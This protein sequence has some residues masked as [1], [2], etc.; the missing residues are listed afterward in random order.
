LTKPAAGTLAAA[1][2]R[3][4]LLAWYDVHARD[5]PWRNAGRTPYRVF[6]SEAMLQQTRV[7][8]VVPYFDRFVEKLPDFAALADADEQEVLGLWQGLGY[9]RRAR[10]LQA[11]ARVIMNE[12]DGVLPRDVHLLRKLPGVGP[13]TAG[14]IASIAL[15]LPEP[16]V[17]GNVAR[18]ITRLDAIEADPA[19]PAVQKH[20]WQRS[21]ALV[22][23]TRPGDFNSSLMELGATVCLPRL[24]HC[25]LCP[26]AEHCK[27]KEANLQDS[28]PPPKQAKTTLIVHR[29]VFRV[30]QGDAVLVEKR[31][32]TGRWAG[33]WQLP[34]R[35]PG[36]PPPVAGN[37][38]P[39]G[40][41]R[42]A[43]THRRYAFRLLDLAVK[44]HAPPDGMRW[45][46][47]D[48]VEK[49]PM[50]VPQRKLLRLQQT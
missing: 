41:L 14:A 21:E 37:Y 40:E 28:I 24:P 26:I 31:P 44:N 12:H 23:P 13:Y 39:T 32:P 6:V 22:D 2:L 4:R 27:A 47:P 8:A 46:D 25:L 19:T 36:S 11:A 29:N 33:L 1:D 20:L 43:L 18:V 7:A 45:A 17:D 9:Y 15:D 38:T 50:S 49:L 30:R 10:N 35:P 16:I 3:R 42:H 5:L 48:A 34:T